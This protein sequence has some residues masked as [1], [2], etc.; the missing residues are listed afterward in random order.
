M[1]VKNKEKTVATNGKIINSMGFETKA[2][3]VG[4]EADPTTS[5]A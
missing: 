1:E 2:I 5:S 4:Q 3:H